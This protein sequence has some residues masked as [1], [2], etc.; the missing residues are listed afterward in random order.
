VTQPT[1]AAPV[2]ISGTTW[3]FA[4]L[5]VTGVSQGQTAFT[6]DLGPVIF[7]NGAWQVS[8]SATPSRASLLQ[9]I[10]ASITGA[11]TTNGVIAQPLSPP[12]AWA[13]TTLFFKGQACVLAGN[14]YV[15]IFQG[16]TGSTGPS[17]TGSAQI[18]DGTA[19]WYY[20]GPTFTAAA[21][22]P[23]VTATATRYSTGT[24]YTNTAAVGGLGAV[25]IKDTTNFLLSPGNDG[26]G[27]NGAY[28]WNLGGLIGSVTFITDAPQFQI[29]ATATANPGMSIYVNG[30]PLTVGVSIVN[31]SGFNYTQLVFADRR[32]RLI[33][34]EMPTASINT[35][36]GVLTNDT[37]SKVSAPVLANNISIAV[38]GTS[39]I[40]GTASIPVTPSLGIGPQ[41]ARL[42]GCN[43]NYWIDGQCTGT[44]YVTPGALTI[45][46]SPA[47]VTN[48]QAFGQPDVLVI[49]GAGINDQGA[50]S[51]VAAGPTTAAALAIEQAA[52]LTALQNYRAAFP[53]A[54]MFVIGS[55]AG[56]TG[57]SAAIFN[58]EL[59]VSN[60]VAQFSDASCF[61]VPQSAQTATKSMIS[62]TGNTGTTN[63]TGNSD[64]YTFTDN[65]HP[66]QAGANYLAARSAAGIIARVNT[67]QG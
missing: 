62:G 28:L 13:A 2:P 10:R 15:C 16:T 60:A 57:P 20:W 34:V 52:V 9:R 50:A 45:F 53:N 64:V 30:V 51:I 67:L 19:V 54:M 26:G 33:T 35:F 29:A 44:G 56:A 5:P 38:T 58:M 63:G 32:E 41:I 3:T 39:Y 23:T 4:T 27:A 66:V 12:I 25:N 37:T 11:Q 61:Y 8:S 1:N 40:Q 7:L 59:A 36:I 31:P 24:S 55:E 21:G 17:G 18:T 46:G 49:T 48:M 47:R 22:A 65:I 43:F 6:S 42:L 14:I